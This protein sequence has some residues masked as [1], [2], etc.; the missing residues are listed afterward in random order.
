M[1]SRI[2]PPIT[3]PVLMPTSAQLT[4]LSPVKNV[5]TPARDGKLGNPGTVI[6]AVITPCFAQ[7]GTNPIATCAVQ[8]IY[9]AEPTA[10][11]P[12]HA[13]PGT[14]TLPPPILP[15]FASINDWILL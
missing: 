4:L 13:S 7:S 9:A 5:S 2:P 10:P 1:M 3:S 12:V 6:G 15:V 14:G 8:L 11:H